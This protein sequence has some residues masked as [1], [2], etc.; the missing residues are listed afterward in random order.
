MNKKRFIITTILSLTIL[1]CSSNVYAFTNTDLMGEYSLVGFEVQYQYPGQSPITQ[2]NASSFSG[3]A[4]ITTKGFVMEM[5]GF[6]PEYGDVKRYNCA[7]YTVVGDRIYAS[8]L[9]GGFGYI[10]VQLSGDTFITSGYDSDEDGY[11]EYTYIWIRNESYYT[12]GQVDQ[13]VFDAVATKD[14]TISDLNQALL[15]KDQTI[16]DLNDTIA[17][18][19][20]T[21]SELSDFNGDGRLDLKDIIWG[22]QVLTGQRL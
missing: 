7:F 1:I 5:E 20:Q 2:Y 18:K 17:Q 3:R 8:I 15:E 19:N 6:F 16:S 10:D 9:G 22:L 14:Q 11:F 4:S 12:Q 21:I 13:T